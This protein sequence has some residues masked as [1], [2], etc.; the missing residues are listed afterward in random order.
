MTDEEFIAEWNATGCRGCVEKWGGDRM[1]YHRKVWQLRADGWYLKRHENTGRP[2]SRDHE[3]IALMTINHTVK[4][5][6]R[7]K[8]MT[9]HQV[10]HSVRMHF[11][12]RGKK[13]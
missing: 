10:Y 2:R 3:S 12:N 7:R 6:A 8:R 11:G 5:V 1:K 4:E 9:I 13:R